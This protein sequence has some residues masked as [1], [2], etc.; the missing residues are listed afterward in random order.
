[1]SEFHRWPCLG[2][3]QLRSRTGSPVD[4]LPFS[5]LSSHFLLRQW[6][7]LSSGFTSL[8]GHAAARHSRRARPYIFTTRLYSRLHEYA[9]AS[10]PQ[11]LFERGDRVVLSHRRTSPSPPPPLPAR[12]VIKLWSGR[13]LTTP[14]QVSRE[15]GFMWFRSLLLQKGNAVSLVRT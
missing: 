15:C 10:G 7:P 4:W 14:Q 12:R 13:T 6:V 2:V 3:P 11:L 9:I 8:P 5:P 1:M